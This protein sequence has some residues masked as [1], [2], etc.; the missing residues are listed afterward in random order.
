MFVI[1]RTFLGDS[2]LCREI[3]RRPL[4]HLGL[5]RTLL[6]LV[7]PARFLAGIHTMLEVFWI[8]A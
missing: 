5:M 1:P 6:P 7:I 8:P 2:I 3:P 4:E